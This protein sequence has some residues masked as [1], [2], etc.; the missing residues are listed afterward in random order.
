MPAKIDLVGRVVRP[1]ARLQRRGA[2]TDPASAAKVRDGHRSL[3]GEGAALVSA[4]IPGF[5]VG[6]VG[7]DEIPERHGERS[8]PG[9]R[10]AGL[11]EG[12]PRAQKVHGRG[13]MGFGHREVEAC[14]E[15]RPGRNREAPAGGLR[16]RRKELHHDVGD[17]GR[18]R[19]ADVVAAER[20][21]SVPPIP[22]ACRSDVWAARE[23]TPARRD[24]STP[25]GRKSGSHS[26]RYHEASSAS[27][28]ER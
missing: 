20:I 4:R 24:V 16:D 25:L 21:M 26:A 11:G 23:A 3:I 27:G 22:P 28:K 15:R 18:R 8:A 9:P 6:P 10:D 13:R 12:E 1:H 5:A 2:E 7:V 19:I 17:G 14:L